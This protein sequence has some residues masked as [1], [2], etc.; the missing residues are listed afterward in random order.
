MQTV[1]GQRRTPPA[2]IIHGIA[3]ARFALGLAGPRSVLLLSAPGAAGFLG[4]GWW[5]ALLRATAAEAQGLLDC[6]HAPGLA[7]AALRLGL[8]RVL[9]LA[10]A[11]GHAAVAAAAAEAG[12]ELVAVRPPALDLRGLDLSHPGAPRKLGAWLD[13]AR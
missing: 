13:A 12:A 10:A 8:P 2:V 7:L 11:P 5:Q 4:P 9:L 1:T 3:D 6:D